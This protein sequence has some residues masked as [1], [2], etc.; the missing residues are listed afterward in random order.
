MWKSIVGAW[1]NVRSGLIKSDPSTAAETF[2]HPLF[3][4]PSILSA[5]GTPLG[6]SGLIEGCAFAQFGCS[7]IKDLWCEK[8]KEWKGLSALGLNHHAS[9]RKCRD[10]IMSSIP[11]HLDEYNCLIR[12]GDWIGK[13]TFGSS[14]TLDWVYL[15]LECTPDKAKTI[16]FK[17][18]TPSGRLQTTMHQ[19]LTI[20]TTNYRPVRVLSQ[21]Y[22]GSTLKVARDPPVPGKKPHLYWIHETGFIPDLPWDPGEWHWR[23]NPPLGDV[24]F[25]GYTAKRGYCNA[26]K[27]ARSS[28]MM[29]FMQGLNLRNST[30]AQMTA[31]LWHNA[32][33]RKV[34]T[35]IWL[36]L[37]Q[38]LPVGTWLQLMG[39]NPICKVCNLN[40]EESALHCLL[41]CPTAQSA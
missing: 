9:N 32:R 18:V 41:E 21:E 33:P 26:R 10:I 4:N 28:N 16:E 3:G 19:P 30:P 2:R 36:T 15:V 6:V 1:L 22:P 27:T 5:S 13:L 37:N 17:K 40:T 35:F 34:G 23:F 14:N 31:R 8:N 38:G 29:T 25:F 39:I 12:A 11:W 24:P 7:R 20:S